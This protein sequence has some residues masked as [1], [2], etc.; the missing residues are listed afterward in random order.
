M[1]EDIVFIYV[2]INQ[3]KL[4]LMTKLK[5]AIMAKIAIAD[6]IALK[7]DI[8]MNEHI[9]KNLKYP[10]DTIIVDQPVSAKYYSREL[11]DDETF[12]WAGYVKPGCHSFLID[13]PIMPKGHPAYT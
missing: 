8:D 3:A 6:K 12:V 7:L 5:C 2:N 10:D 9:C 11:E 13:D 1:I 4:D